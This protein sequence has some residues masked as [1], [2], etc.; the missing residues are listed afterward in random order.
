[1]GMAISSQAAAKVAEGSTTRRS[2]LTSRQLREMY[3][4]MATREI[5]AKLDAPSR[6]VT[7]WLH[8]AG[9]ELRQPGEKARTSVLRD[10]GWLYRQY[11]ALNKSAEQI[12]AE[13]DITPRTIIQWLRRHDISVRASNRGRKFSPEVVANMSAS[14]RGKR[15]GDKNPNWRGGRVDPMARERQSYAHKAWSQ[16]VRRRDGKCMQCGAT[17]RLHA[18]HVQ[19]WHKHPELRY[20]A[21]NGV[22]LCARCHQKVHKFPFPA[23]AFGETSTSA[24]HPSRVMR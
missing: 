3:A 5:A 20:V 13:T 1:M 9:I 16:A 6:T 12:S 17:E 19:S 7:R 18:H 2:S 22:T 24:G 15:V 11:I 8:R 23:W 21:T 10:R 14:K 4:T